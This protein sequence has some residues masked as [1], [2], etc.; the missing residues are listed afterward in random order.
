LLAIN[1]IILSGNE[2]K[3]DEFKYTKALFNARLFYAFCFNAPYQS[4]QLPNLCS[5]IFGLTLFGW[6]ISIY[7]SVLFWEN[8]F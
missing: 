2:I 7:L 8:H 3:K 5:L 4:T 1:L 6:F